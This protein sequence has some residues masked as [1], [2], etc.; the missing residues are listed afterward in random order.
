MVSLS[1]SNSVEIYVYAYLIIE[2]AAEMM[3]FCLLT[4][5]TILSHARNI[6][7]KKNDE[8]CTTKTTKNEIQ[9]LTTEIVKYMIHK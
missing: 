6:C 7:S 2:I 1:G 3:I 9:M 8:T 4:P 5:L